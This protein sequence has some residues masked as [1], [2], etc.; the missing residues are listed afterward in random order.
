VDGFPAGLEHR[1]D[2]DAA[3]QGGRDSTQ[4]QTL[5]LK[6]SEEVAAGKRQE[7]RDFQDGRRKPAQ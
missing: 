2:D 7:D 5:V 3:Q 6:L 1:P 4:P